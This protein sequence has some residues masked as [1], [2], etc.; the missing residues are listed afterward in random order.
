[1]T[2]RV[3]FMAEENSRSLTHYYSKGLLL[4][5]CYT[6]AHEGAEVGRG[7]QITGNN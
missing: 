7:V 6:P 5:F 4:L 1:M 2:T 3:R